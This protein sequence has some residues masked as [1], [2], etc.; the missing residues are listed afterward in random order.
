MTESVFTKMLKGEIPRDI[1]YQDDTCFVIPTI[2][3]HTEG[4][5]MVIPN[6]QIDNWEYLDDKTYQ[7]CMKVAQ[8][9]GRVLKN[10]YNCPKV[11]VEIV[12][13]EVPHVHIHLIP[14]YK[15]IDMDHTQAHKVEPDE[16]KVVAHK[17]RTAIDKQGGL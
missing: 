7:H 8:K 12:G 2:E 9:L 3:P 14:A 1:V 15:I 13:F 6:E 11:V 16:L 10:L 17:I 5:I 4:H